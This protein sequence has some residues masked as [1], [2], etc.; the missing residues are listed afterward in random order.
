MPPFRSFLDSCNALLALRFFAAGLCLICFGGRSIHASIQT[1]RPNILFILADDMGFSDA[2]CYGGEIST[3]NLD[4][5]AAHGVR[6]TQFYNTARCWPTRA[7]LL[8]G[9]YPQQIR[10]DPP[11]GRLPGWAKLL[12][13]YLKPLGYRS[14]HS[15]KWHVNGAPR[16]L[17]DGGFDR[18][19]RLE[20]HDHN[21][22]PANIWLDDVRLPPVPKG[23]NYYTTVAFADFMIDCLK[24]HASQFA[25]RPFFAY[26]A[27]TVPHFPL[28]APPEDIARYRDK[29][30]DGWD[31][32]RTQRHERQK[33]MG[34]L[35]CALSPREPD[36]VPHWNLT[37]AQLHEQISPHEVA[38]AVAWDQLTPEEKRFQ[39]TKMAIHAAMIDRM[40][41]EIGRVVAQLEAMN[42]LENT[43]IM[44]ASDNG[45][46]A[47]FL[48]R[49]DKHD[50]SA[51]AGSGG[52]FLCLGPGWATAANA[53]FRLHKSWVHEGGISTPLI[54]QWPA[55]IRAKGE[56]RHAVG[57][58]IDIL[59][60]VLALTGEPL[61]G[62]NAAPVLPGRSLLPAFSQDAP[63]AREFLYFHHENNRAL[64]MGDW[65]LVSKRPNTNNYA[66]YNLAA[67]RCEQVDLASTDPD[68][69]SAMARRWQELELEYRRSAE[70]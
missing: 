1:N 31:A 51:P 49:G 52:S 70:P 57:H 33:A 58:M 62:T 7:A 30:L 60:T 41:R 15:G 6:F 11:Q 65:K 68:R 47:E 3:P 39:A 9:Y 45:A 53:P 17:A 18:S 29:Y 12:P 24:Q 36:V 8:S 19:Y 44:F 43:I 55:A 22:Y 38:A 61:S 67:D 54:V 59:P 20:D 40:D 10:M 56:L 32:I 23:T 37:A 2:G 5:L 16:S 28:Q 27:F 64:R 14:Y 50:P 13:Q 69:A 48:N 4:R 63:I 35:N 34:I 25:D 42:A 26:L 66:L 46:S 21:F